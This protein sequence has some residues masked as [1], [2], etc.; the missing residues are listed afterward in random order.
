MKKLLKIG[1]LSTAT[2][3]LATGCNKDLLDTNYT[4][5]YALCNHP[6]M[7]EKID[8]YKWKDY[9]DGEQIQIIST[10]GKTYL[11]NSMYCVLIKD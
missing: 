6:Q 11:V 10:D 7:P 5:D 8:I 1:I 3:L 9:E 4:Y 2:L